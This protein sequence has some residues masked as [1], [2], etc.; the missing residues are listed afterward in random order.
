MSGLARSSVNR[1]L[2]WLLILVAAALFTGSVVY[3]ASQAHP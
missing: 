1:R 2:L 3:I